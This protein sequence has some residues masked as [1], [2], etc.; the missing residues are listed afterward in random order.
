MGT[1][2]R[3][4]V[5]TFPGPTTPGPAFLFL[6]K[7]TPSPPLK[8]GVLSNS[9]FFFFGAERGKHGPPLENAPPLW[10]PTKKKNPKCSL[11]RNSKKPPQRKNKRGGGGTP[12]PKN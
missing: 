7:K 5:P 6:P 4:P 11:P 8:L 1:Q 10:P 3:L 2:G 12:P 9:N